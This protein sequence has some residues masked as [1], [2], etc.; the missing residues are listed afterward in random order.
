MFSRGYTKAAVWVK[1]DITPPANAQPDDPLTVLIKPVFL[2]QIQL[3]DP[4]DT[5]GV[6]RIAGDATAGRVLDFV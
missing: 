1:V 3:F 2:D 5:R 6:P 4:L